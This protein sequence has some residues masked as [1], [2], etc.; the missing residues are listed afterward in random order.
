M[1]QENELKQPADEGRLEPGVGRHC[2]LNA[3]MPALRVLVPAN[4]EFTGRTR[5]GGT[6]C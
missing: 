6:P 2:P 5:S 3:Q 4:A 1:T